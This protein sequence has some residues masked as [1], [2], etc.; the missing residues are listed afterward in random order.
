MYW[1]A[2]KTSIQRTRTGFGAPPNCS[3]QST[4]TEVSAFGATSENQNDGEIFTFRL[5]FHTLVLIFLHF[6][7]QPPMLQRLHEN[8]TELQNRKFIGFP[9]KRRLSGQKRALEPL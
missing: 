1:I 8:P 2:F 3:F 7:R 9:L 6:N 5:L 4:T